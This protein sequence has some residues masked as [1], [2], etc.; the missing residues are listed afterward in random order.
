VGAWPYCYG[1][2]M[3]LDSA[4]SRYL[5][6]RRGELR[7]QTW[8][9]Q[10]M[11]LERF[12]AIYGVRSVQSI[13]EDDVRAWRDTFTHAKPQSVNKYIDRIKAFFRYAERRGWVT[14][15]PARNVESLDEEPPRRP[16]IPADAFVKMLDDARHP[17]DRAAMALALELMLRGGEI[18][19]LRVRD[20]NLDDLCVT[21]HL[22]KKKGV[23]VE[24]EMAISPNLGQEVHSWLDAYRSDCGLL[25]PSY[26][27]FPRI[28]TA[29]H[30][31]ATVYRVRPQAPMGSPWVVVGHALRQL[32]LYET[33]VGF[34]AVRRSAARVL[35]DHLCENNGTDRAL[36]H[37]SSV[38]HHSSRQV[39]EQ[40][41]GIEGDR[42]ARNKI[43][44]DTG[45]SVLSLA[46][47]RADVDERKGLAS[48]T[49]LVYTG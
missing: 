48:V 11:T 9:K 27:L 42:L 3:D 23:L 25:A 13:T 38:L 47:A 21:V 10:R 28:D 26:Y 17:R 41:L 46:T 2:R 29:R 45:V 32:G 34:H 39:T 36:S 19:R 44:R 22:E 6:E 8:N 4:I 43:V 24:D 40:Y 16:R 7:P 20:V 37:V 35:F 30:G 49:P 31:T 5:Y 18:A 15:D 33:G 12:G 1:R 14:I